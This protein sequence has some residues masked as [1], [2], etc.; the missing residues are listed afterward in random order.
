MDTVWISFC[1]IVFVG[2]Y[3]PAT[4]YANRE[5]T[6]VKEDETKREK[7]SKEFILADN[8][9]MI[10]VYS[11][12]VHFEDDG[13][14][15]DID[16]TLDSVQINGKSVLQNRANSFTVRLPQQLSSQSE[17]AI[18]SNEEQKDA[19]GHA[20]DPAGANDRGS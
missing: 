7:Y 10:A 20:C 16:N 13:A 3:I 1:S 12:A 14:W 4:V 6:V 19:D 18:E 15:V 8:S 17:I 2:V 5:K 9:R 11:S